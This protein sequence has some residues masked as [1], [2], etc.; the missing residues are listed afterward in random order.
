MLFYKMNVTTMF[1][2]NDPRKTTLNKKINVTGK[3]TLFSSI[4]L[5]IEGN[6]VMK[7][8]SFWRIKA[9]KRNLGYY[10]WDASQSQEVYFYIFFCG[11]PVTID[12]YG[13]SKAPCSS[14]AQ[15]NRVF[16][17][18]I[19]TFLSHDHCDTSEPMLHSCSGILLTFSAGGKLVYK[20]R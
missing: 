8:N 12:T 14:L 5:F 2:G 7:C 11:S 13:W 20:G 19:W 4:S 18:G 3:Y 9:H 10:C 17:W 15:E 1:A 6:S 16:C